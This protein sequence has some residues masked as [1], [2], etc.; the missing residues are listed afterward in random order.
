[1]NEK[2]AAGKPADVVERF[3]NVWSLPG[4]DERAEAVAALWAADGVE[5]VEGRVF[6]GRAE[7]VERVTT[8]YEAFI[9]NG[10]YVGRSAGDL[11]VHDD[12][13]RFTVELREP[14]SAGAQPGEL[15]WAARV[16]LLLDEDGLVR[17]SYQI[18][19]K[20]LPPA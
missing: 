3:I 13:L 1:V 11:T 2:S 19:V 14:A 8:A 16:F 4:E 17:Q 7:L 5:F 18:T 15:A 10:K 20:P 9:G 12:L 6:E